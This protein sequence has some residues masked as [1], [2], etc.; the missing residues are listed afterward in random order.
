MNDGR[1][2]HGARGLKCRVCFG[3]FGAGRRRAP[4][5]A[6]GLKFDAEH[7]GGSLAVSRPARGAW[8]EIADLTEAR[9]G[10]ASRPARGAW[11]EIPW[12]F[13]VADKTGGR[14]PHGARGLKCCRRIGKRDSSRRAPHGAR[15]LKY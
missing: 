7:I 11:I 2:P 14:A 8:I 6:R 9:H 5:G 1:A 10:A 15:G 3:A 4:H 13:P 12:V